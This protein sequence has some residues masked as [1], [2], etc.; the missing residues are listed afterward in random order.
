MIVKRQRLLEIHRALTALAEHA[1]GVKLSYA[2]ARNLGRLREEVEAIQKAGSPSK[3]FQEFE[4]ARVAFC[5]ALAVKDVQGRPVVEQGQYVIDDQA[6][7]NEHVDKLREQYTEAIS[8]RE[9]QIT[10]W[11][12][13]LD[14]EVDVRFHLVALESVEGA[15]AEDAP[16]LALLLEPLLGYVIAEPAT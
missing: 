10:E 9:K 7:L 14:G 13:L 8:E 1:R 2:I 12:T 5:Q 3:A 16:S 15:V 11:R 4:Q 6:Q